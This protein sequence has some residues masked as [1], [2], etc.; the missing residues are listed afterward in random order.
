MS[1]YVNVTRDGEKLAG[2]LTENMAFSWLLR[3]QTKSVDLAITE[4]GYAFEPTEWESLKAEDIFVGRTA[5][6]TRVYLDMSLERVAKEGKTSVTHEPVTDEFFRFSA[7]GHTV[8]KGR[9]DDNWDGGGQ[10]LDTLL[11]VADP[12]NG[13]TL[14]EL[15]EIHR[16]WKNWH[17]NDMQAGCQHVPDPLWEDSPYGKRPDLKNTPSC[18]ETGY[19]WGSAWLVRLIPATVI[20]RMQE[21]IRK[22]I[23]SA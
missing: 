19:R 2:P 16:L 20:V 5:E 18:P 10:M 8:L 4:E 15:K 9:R 23:A 13:W 17:L 14:Q 7:S 21:L 1:N 22:A 6:G 11:E 3:H 12:A